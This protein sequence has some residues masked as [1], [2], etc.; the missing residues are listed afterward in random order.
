MLF[1]DWGDGMK[2][3]RA[4]CLLL[5]ASAG[6]ATAN[7]FDS[8]N[9]G[10]TALNNRNFGAAISYLSQAISPGDLAPDLMPV[11]LV[12]RGAA[13][14][15]EGKYTE[16][17]ADFD[18]ALKLRPQYFEALSR[19]AG[20]LAA[21]GDKAAAQTDCESMLKLWPYNP[22]VHEICGRLDWEIGN[23][24]EA[25][26]RF[27][28]ALDLNPHSKYSFLWLCLAL[29][30]AHS[31]LKSTVHAFAPDIDFDGWPS[32]IIDL[33][34][35]NGSIERAERAA[36]DG[37]DE[38]K[39]NQGCEVGFY[40]GEWQLLRGNAVAGRAL[41]KEATELCPNDFIEAEPAKSELKRWSEA[42]R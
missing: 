18:A 42:T 15:G 31:E 6:W 9:R 4:A 8:F 5:V 41:L 25:T 23:Y 14:I 37:D 10:V 11:A 28:S 40:G 20:A 19:R 12:D 26:N 33:Y 3:V 29:L 35:G 32:P 16:A 24:S 21:G 7:S 34:L 36:N 27:E 38:T 39:R 17:I 13:Y 2:S 22:T 30:N 1:V